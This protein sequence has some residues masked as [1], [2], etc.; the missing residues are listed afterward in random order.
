[1]DLETFFRDLYH[2]T[3]AQWRVILTLLVC[4]NLIVYAT[5]TWL[6]WAYIYRQPPPPELPADL[7]LTPTLRPTYTPTWT[8]T[9]NATLVRTSTPV[10]TGTPAP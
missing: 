7:L 10:A 6:W 4:A 1:V 3:A 9:A 5:V 8:P 2:L